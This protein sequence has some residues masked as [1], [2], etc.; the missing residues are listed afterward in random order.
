MEQSELLATKDSPFD[1]GRFARRHQ[2]QPFPGLLAS[3]AHPLSSLSTP[4]NACRALR[5][6]SASIDTST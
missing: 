4:S 2:I 6:S 5:S 1:R 3:F